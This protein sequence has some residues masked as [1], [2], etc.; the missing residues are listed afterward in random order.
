MVMS[1]GGRIGEG[2]FVGFLF[3]FVGSLPCLLYVVKHSYH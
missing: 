2:E 1:S 3:L